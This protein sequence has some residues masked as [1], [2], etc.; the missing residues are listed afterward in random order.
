VFGYMLIGVVDDDL[1]KKNFWFYGVCVFGM[2]DEFLYIFWD[3]K[4]DEF[5]IV[6]FLVF[7]E[8]C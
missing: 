2:I 6:I 8:V 1:C 5:L 4:L 7:G 3:N